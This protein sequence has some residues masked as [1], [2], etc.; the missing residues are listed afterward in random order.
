MKTYFTDQELPVYEFND[1][2]LDPVRRQL[3]RSDEFV[4]MPPKVFDTLLALV[5]DH[6]RIVEKDE[7]IEAVWPDTMVE[8][9][10]LTQNISAI[11]K[12]LGDDRRENSYVATIPGRGYRFVAPVRVLP[13]GATAPEKGRT[14]ALATTA[15]T[16][17]RRPAKR[18]VLAL[19][20]ALA[21]LTSLSFLWPMSKA[22]RAAA[23]TGLAYTQDRDAYAAYMK[24]DHLMREPSNE[25][26]KKSIE[27]FRWA[28]D[29]D[30]DYALAYAGLADTYMRLH[31]RGVAVDDGS[32][33]DLARES[34]QRALQI[35]DS[36]AYA[37]SIRGFIAFRYEWDFERAEKEYKRVRE[38]DPNYVHSWFGFYLLTVNRYAEA[39]DEFRRFQVAR[40]LESSDIYLYRYFLR[41]YD[42]AQTELQTALDVNADD[43]PNHANLGIIYEQKGLLREAIDEFSKSRAISG[44]SESADGLAAHALAI[45]G[46]KS[47]ARKILAKMM[48]GSTADYFSADY[49]VAVVNAGLGEKDRAI[50]Y[51]ERAFEKHALGPAWLRFDPRLDDLRSEPRF[52]TLLRRTGLRNA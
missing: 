16:R 40:P 37:H 31:S 48:E 8:E 26:I 22:P 12:T 41:R 47:E 15:V 20:T 11:R 13:A 52:Q 30:P 33:I 45:S 6:G 29:L 51:L 3:R 24:A 21:C 25:K 39:E 34:I 38:L 42:M 50:D 1:F 19:V 18:Y 46:R 36:V 17:P 28:I 32:P 10:N 23:S 9:N 49:M 7:L 4:P 44:K 5:R 43:A 2:R 14:P 27:Y 35:D